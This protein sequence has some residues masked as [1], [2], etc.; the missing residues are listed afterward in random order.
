MNRRQQIELLKQYKEMIINQKEEQEQNKK[1]E[2]QKVK[3]LRKQFYG[4]NLI[5]G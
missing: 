4:R 2:K 5:V 1:H 3:V